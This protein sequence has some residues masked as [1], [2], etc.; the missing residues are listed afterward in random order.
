MSPP[1]RHLVHN[2][3]Q[4]RVRKLPLHTLLRR[5]WTLGARRA[6]L[7]ALALR[8]DR[9]QGLVDGVDC[10]E[11]VVKAHNSFVVANQR[12]AT[13]PVLGAR[14]PQH[15]CDFRILFVVLKGRLVIAMPGQAFKHA[16]E[17]P[18]RAVA[19]EEIVNVDSK[20]EQVIFD[21]RSE[22]VNQLNAAN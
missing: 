15:E 13:T 8:V 3:F 10:V 4:F 7:A 22:P 16:F 19:G 9:N 20:R 2:G 18:P 21:L 14:H 1:A 11:Q 5:L 17:L 6:T 12:D